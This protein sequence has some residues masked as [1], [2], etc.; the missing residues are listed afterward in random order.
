[1]IEYTHE[2]MNQGPGIV[3][4]LDVYI[5]AEVWRAEGPVSLRIEKIGEWEPMHRP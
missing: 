4:A 2:V 3:K 5:S 1:M